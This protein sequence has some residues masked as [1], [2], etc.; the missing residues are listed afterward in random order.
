MT[1]P[2]RPVVPPTREETRA[3]A[4]SKILEAARAHAASHSARW[5]EC[6]LCDTWRFYG[7]AADGEPERA[8]AER[9]GVRAYA[10]SEIIQATRG[11]A[12]F[13][14]VRWGECDLCEAWSFYV[15][16]RLG[17]P[18]RARAERLE[19]LE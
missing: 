12:N 11:H 1:A 19:W 17:E 13:H 7:P 4:V 2:G 8:R 9:L 15:Q 6:G 3:Q 5:G 16:V 10:I 14:S 18:D